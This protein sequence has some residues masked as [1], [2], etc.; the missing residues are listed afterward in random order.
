MEDHTARE[1]QEH[2]STGVTHTV[3]SVARKLPGVTFRLQ[4]SLMPKTPQN[5]S[6]PLS[7]TILSATTIWLLSSGFFSSFFFFFKIEEY[8]KSFEYSVFQ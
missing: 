4:C 8:E 6:N 3:L 1:G 2:S 7:H 5:A